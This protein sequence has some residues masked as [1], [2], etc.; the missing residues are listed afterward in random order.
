MTSQSL[1]EQR[2]AFQE[3]AWSRL[4]NNL[5]VGESL[6][7]IKSGVYKSQ[8]DRLRGYLI[9]GNREQYELEKKMLPAVTFSASF[10]QKRNRSSIADYNS[11]LVL[12]IDKLE[13]SVIEALKQGFY[14]DPHILSYWESPS[15]AGIKGLIYLSFPENFPI[16]DLNVKHTYAFNKVSKYITEKYAVNLD[17]SGSDI[18]RLCFFSQDESLLIKESIHPF[19]INYDPAD[20]IIAREN[21]RNTNYIYRAKPTADQQFNPDGRNRQS[22]RTHIQ[23][24]LKFLKK[25]HLSITKSFSNWYQVGYTL[26]NTFTYDLG[27]KYFIELSKMDIEKYKPLECQDMIDYCYA[28]SQGAYTFATIIHFAKKVG[29]GEKKGVPKTVDVSN[30]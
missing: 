15:K 27:S 5:T 23:A 10:D 25:R 13:K 2:V 3:N 26:A 20:E 18:T 9:N 11:L 16:V 6:K 22:D 24:I 28:N 8:I 29:Y 30:I 19:V 4:S 14:N 1:L 21:D 17:S 12:D 7:I